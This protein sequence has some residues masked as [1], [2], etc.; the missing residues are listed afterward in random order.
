MWKSDARLEKNEMDQLRKG[1]ATG[2]SCEVNFSSLADII[3]LYRGTKRA[4]SSDLPYF[5]ILRTLVLCVTT[6]DIKLS[7][8]FSPMKNKLHSIPSDLALGHDLTKRS[9]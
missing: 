3:C 2:K 7:A 5:T 8:K 4:E 6:V 9:K 1:K